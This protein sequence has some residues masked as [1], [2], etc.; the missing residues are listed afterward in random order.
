MKY[1]NRIVLF[2]D[3]LGFKKIVQETLEKGPEPNIPIDNQEKI[4]GLHALLAK[5]GATAA[6]H[7][8]N[9][10]INVTQFSDSIVISFLD[11][12]PSQAALTFKIVLKIIVELVKNGILCRGALSEGKLIHTNQTIFGPALVDAYETETKAAMYPR[13]IMDKKIYEFAKMYPD[14]V[15]G[16]LILPESISDVIKNDLDG[17]YYINYFGAV[18]TVINDPQEL[19][20]YYRSLRE[21]II[22]GRKF[23]QPDLKVKY[24]WMRTKYNRLLKR[25]AERDERLNLP[26]ALRDYL[27]QLK[28]LR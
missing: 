16:E 15:T 7:Q 23:Q 1:E 9:A 19:G 5:M 2:L 27:A 17:K 3:I 13:V 10:K 18:H 14:P 11:T 12:Q 8:T 21:I 6:D 4:A 28:Q 20:A 25:A 24:G 22:N 26:P